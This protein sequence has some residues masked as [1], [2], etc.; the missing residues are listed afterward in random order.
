M[1]IGIFRLD[2]LRHYY[3]QFIDAL[4]YSL[5]NHD[6]SEIN[7]FEGNDTWD[8]VFIISHVKI[9][10]R[11][12][13]HLF[14]NNFKNIKRV[15]VY[16]TDPLT[17]NHDIKNMYKFLNR[18]FEIWTYT[19]KNVMLIKKN[20][21]NVVCHYFPLGYSKVYDYSTTNYSFDIISLV[22][23]GRKRH[24]K[25]CTKNV[26][27][28]WTHEAWKN[29]VCNNQ[30]IINVHKPERDALE[31]FRLSPL[32]SSGVTVISRESFHQDEEEMK[33]LVTFKKKHE[34]NGY[35]VMLNNELKRNTRE[36]IQLRR[37]NIKKK[38]REKFDLEEMLKKLI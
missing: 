6:I 7:K 13:L 10:K 23:C 22:A 9:L 17:E 21:P 27:D 15:I 37:E 38:F 26:D 16:E 20:I 30:I 34:I 36:Q 25:L 33:H 18:P 2:I 31:M 5:K 4:L 14:N 1:K 28:A 29:R 8:V 3:F 19:H 11:D 32:L 12:C 35:S 24:E